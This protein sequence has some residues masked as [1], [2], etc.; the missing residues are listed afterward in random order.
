[1]RNALAHAGRSGRRVVCAFIATAFAQDDAAAAS[2]QWRKVADQL[3][4]TVPKLAALMDTAETDVL[5]Y[6]TFP[7]QHRAKLHST[8]WSAS[9]ARS[10]TALRSSAS[11]P[12]MPPSSARR[13]DPARTERRVW[14]V[15]QARYITLEGNAPISDDPN[16]SLPAVAP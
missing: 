14:A 9:T 8:R 3:R 16:V 10:S 7:T 13:C 15:Q 4:P 12:T 6:M 2:Q 11:S 1:M 5:A